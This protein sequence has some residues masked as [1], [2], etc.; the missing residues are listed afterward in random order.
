MKF[1]KFKA[2]KILF[3]DIDNNWF[4][5]LFSKTLEKYNFTVDENSSGNAE[6]AIDPEM[7]GRIFENLLAEQNP[8]TGESAR[9]A[10]GSF[11]TPREIVDY[12]VEQSVS[13]YLKT[14]LLW[15]EK[16]NNAIDEF[17]HTQ[18]LPIALEKYEELLSSELNKIKV[19]DPACGSG[20]FPIGILQ[21]IIALKQQLHPK[22]KNYKLKLD[23]IQNSIYGVDIQPMAVELSRLRCWLSLVVDEDPNDIKALPNLDFKFVCADSLVD[24]PVSDYVTHDLELNLKELEENVEKYFSPDYQ[25]KKKLQEDIKRNIASISKFHHN[26][27]AQLITKIRKEEK[28]ASPSKLKQLRE[29]IMEYSEMDSKW[30]TYENIFNGKKVDFFNPI[31]FFPSAKSGFDIVIGNPPYISLSKIQKE[32]L[33]NLSI[34]SYQTFAKGADIYCLFYERGVRLLK[35][36]AIISY[37]SSNRF[38]FTNYGVGLRKYLSEQNILQIINFNQINVF[39]SANVGSAVLVVQ[40]AEPSDNPILTFESKENTIDNLTTIVKNKGKK[41]SR[42]YFKEAQWS[43]DQNEIQELKQ[44]IEKMGIPFIKWKHISINRGITTG[45]NDVFIISESIR[46]EILKNDPISEEILKP[47]LKGA[48]IKRY[49]IL[50]PKE[51]LVYTFTDIDINKYPGV[52]NY[53]NKYRTQLEEVYEAKHGMKKWYELR[54]CTYYDKFFEPKL[55]WTRLSNQNAFAISKN[56]EFTV[57]SSSFAVTE[58]AKYLSAVLNSKVVFFYFNLGSVIWGKDGIKWFG[59][60]FDNIPIPEIERKKQQPFITIVDFILYTKEKSGK[61]SIH[62]SVSD[63]LIVKHFEDIIDGMVLELYFEEEM[64]L[65]NVN[66]I[67]LIEKEL[68][69]IESENIAESI[70][71]FYR[72]VSTPDSEIRNRILLFPIVSPDILK[73]ILQG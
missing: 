35:N 73:P 15:D 65:K 40:K 51:Y 29:K 23:T 32:T 33:N 63:S 67:D 72:S 34:Q 31:F 45:L 38:C 56:G 44:K 43:F 66:I 13:E 47:V 24:V 36:N 12:M 52:L 58:D 42:G 64:K 54:K 46:N 3:L 8:E 5:S 10:T 6:I 30:N 11:Y 20:A 27:I 28:I 14:A 1:F 49:A 16:N 57:D 17:V 7:L 68:Q 59:S 25:N 9:K 69:K 48:N 2:V 22:I 18:T 21:K 37:I 71:S 26:I 53:L 61:E 41:L 19:I 62:Q 39:E 60:Y 50:E 4:Y 70:Y 55:V